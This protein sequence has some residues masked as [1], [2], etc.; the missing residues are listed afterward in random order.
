VKLVAYIDKEGK[1]LPI[2]R[3]IFGENKEPVSVMYMKYGDNWNDGNYT[4]SFTLIET[5]RINDIKS[6]TIYNGTTLFSPV[7]K[8][9]YNVMYYDGS[10]IL[11]NDVTNI[12]AQ[13]NNKNVKELQLENTGHILSE[14]DDD[15]EDEDEDEE[16]TNIDNNEDNVKEEFKLRLKYDYDNVSK[17]AYIKLNQYNK[18]FIEMN[19]KPIIRGKLEKED[20]KKAFY[21]KKSKNKIPKHVELIDETKNL[22]L[23]A[24]IT[25]NKHNKYYVYYVLKNGN[26]KSLVWGDVSKK[27][28]KKK[29]EIEKKKLK[30]IYEYIF[31]EDKTD[32]SKNIDV[33]VLYF[34]KNNQGRYIIKNNS[35]TTIWGN[36][37]K[38]HILNIFEKYKK[39]VSHEVKLI[40][41]DT[42]KNE[43]ET[44]KQDKRVDALLKKTNNT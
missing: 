10:Y 1:I 43:L 16:D 4:S 33:E 5:T 13:L 36:N 18:F 26:K 23:Q 30:R 22:V 3:V 17:K 28:V 7:T 32:V 40:L 25:K 37:D 27:S 34:C 15:E 14:D 6:K 21:K 44:E 38:T 2:S 20:V 11:H 8:I 29:F 24:Y 31:L 42:I 39:D 41:D 9:T 12:N 19:G 35:K